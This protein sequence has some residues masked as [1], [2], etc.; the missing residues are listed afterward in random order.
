MVK[1]SHRGKIYYTTKIEVE[2][3]RRKGDRVYYAKGIGYY[4][5]RPQKRG[6]F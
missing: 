4:I 2:K 1:I 3:A 5:V 6:W